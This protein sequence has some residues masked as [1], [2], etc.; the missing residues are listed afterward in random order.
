M[1]GESEVG[2]FSEL[3]AVK[4]VIGSIEMSE[5]LAALSVSV[6]MAGVGGIA[7]VG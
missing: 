6:N 1:V 5:W 7:E 3:H 2:G 4:H